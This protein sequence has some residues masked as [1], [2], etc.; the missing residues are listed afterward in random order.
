M[1]LEISPRRSGKTTRLLEAVIKHCYHNPDDVVCVIVFNREMFYLM[2]YLLP[3]GVRLF[4]DYDNIK[5]RIP[6][7]H[8]NIM[9]FFDEFEH[10]TE[11]FKNSHPKDL[12]GPY[13][14]KYYYSTTLSSIHNDFIIN[15]LKMN[16]GEYI[17]YKS[18]DKP[19]KHHIRGYD[20]DTNDELSKLFIL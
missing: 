9:M 13:N 2:E 3:R 12:Y 1:Y 14:S 7:V 17:T 16:G 5:R 10:L 6:P 20:N 18:Y 4:T 15:L 8:S 11:I 19:E